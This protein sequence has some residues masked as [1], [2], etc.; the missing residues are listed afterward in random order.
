[1]VY[2][3]QTSSGEAPKGKGLK[4]ALLCAGIFVVLMAVGLAVLWIVWLQ[5]KGT[6][7]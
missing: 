1:M 3:T 2:S 7:A 4:V 5:S 6:V